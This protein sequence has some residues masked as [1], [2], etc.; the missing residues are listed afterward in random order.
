MG[1]RN[2]KRNVIFRTPDIHKLDDFIDFMDDDMDDLKLNNLPILKQSNDPSTP[3]MP[4]PIP[5]EY[6]G[7]RSNDSPMTLEEIMMDLDDISDDDDAHIPFPGIMYR[8][9]SDSDVHSFD[10]NDSLILPLKHNDYNKME[11]MCPINSDSAF[12]IQE[13]IDHPMSELASN[14]S[15]DDESSPRPSPYRVTP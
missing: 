8:S 2:E 5:S 13:L 6:V 9:F 11:A 1:T 10:T 3:L 15:F 4:T 14:D 7:H 12:I